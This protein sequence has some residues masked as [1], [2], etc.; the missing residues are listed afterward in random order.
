MQS[1]KLVLLYE[2]KYFR[3]SDTSPPVYNDLGEFNGTAHLSVG[4]LLD[5]LSVAA[6]DHSPNG[7]GRLIDE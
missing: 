5:K 4:L 7:S 1:Q 6:V 2:N 3:S